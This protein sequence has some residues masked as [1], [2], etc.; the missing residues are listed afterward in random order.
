MVFRIS[1]HTAVL[2]GVGE[3][4]QQGGDTCMGGNDRGCGAGTRRVNSGRLA[5][6]R[7]RRNPRK[8]KFRLKCGGGGC[9]IPVR[10]HGVG[11]VDSDSLRVFENAEVA[12]GEHGDGRGTGTGHIRQDQTGEHRP[13]KRQSVR[14]WQR[15]LQSGIQESVF[16]VWCRTCLP[17]LVVIP[18]VLSP[19]AEIFPV[20]IESGI[21][22]SILIW[23]GGGDLKSRTRL[24]QRI[25]IAF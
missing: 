17:T 22:T 7:G 11:S 13:I 23:L 18:I 14:D 19:A 3:R 21:K 12:G 8:R 24:A 20:T 9:R 4:L 6:N 15:G 10:G 25:G 16:P 2:R 1:L 5:R